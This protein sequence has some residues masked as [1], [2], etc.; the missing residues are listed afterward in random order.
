MPELSRRATLAGRMQDTLAM[1]SHLERAIRRVE[2]R[3]I[4]GISI[5]TPR[6]RITIFPPGDEDYL[7]DLIDLRL[8][9]S[10]LFFD[11]NREA[12]WLR[13]ADPYER[14]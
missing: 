11:L 7:N 6:G 4:Y 8:E 3:L 1:L 13:Y 14:L 2:H 10:Q 5:S 12:N 9:T